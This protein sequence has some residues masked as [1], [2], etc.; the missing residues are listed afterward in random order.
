MRDLGF[1]DLFGHGSF[2]MGAPE[3]TGV[4]GVGGTPV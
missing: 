1:V 3:A 4:G 2:T